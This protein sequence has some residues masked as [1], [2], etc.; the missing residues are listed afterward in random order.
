MPAVVRR[1]RE[2]HPG[3]YEATRMAL[4]LE[5]KVPGRI[6]EA[7]DEALGIDVD[8]LRKEHRPL[9]FY[10]LHALAQGIGEEAMNSG[11]ANI[12]KVLDFVAHQFGGDDGLFRDR[13]VTGSS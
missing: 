13:D 6:A 1:L 7:F 4:L 11:N 10:T 8:S 2:E 5:S 9:H 12:V 3:S